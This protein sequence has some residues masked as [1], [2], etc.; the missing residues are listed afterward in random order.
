MKIL[1]AEDDPISRRILEANLLEW[2]YEA[3]V[4]SDGGEAWEIIQ[5]PESPSLI[6]S[7]GRQ[8]SAISGEQVVF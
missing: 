6:I 2:G 3:M 8:L 7:E 1:I 5:Q 4:A